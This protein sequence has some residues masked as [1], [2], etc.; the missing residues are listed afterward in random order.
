MRAAPR[1]T[2]SPR[3]VS[4][5]SKAAKAAEVL[6]YLA[7][8]NQRRS[9]FVAAARGAGLDDVAIARLLKGLRASAAEVI[10]GRITPRAG[11]AAASA[12]AR[13]A[14]AS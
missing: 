13:A 4:K 9:E 12:L 7:L 1:S 5:S 10:A 3:S 6:K 14:V 11:I 2:T 8:R